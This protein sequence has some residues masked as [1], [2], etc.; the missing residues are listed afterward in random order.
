MRFEVRVS[1][2]FDFCYALADLISPDPHF[3]GWPAISQAPNWLERARALGWPLWLAVPDLI[4]REEPQESTDAFLDALGARPV[5]EIEP[6]LRRALFHSDDPA[7]PRPEKREWLHFIGLEKDSRGEFLKGWGGRVIDEVI[8]CLRGFQPEFDAAWSALLPQLSRSAAKARRAAAGGDLAKI[9]RTLD[10]AVEVDSGERVVRALRGGYSLPIGEVGTAYLMPSAFNSR[11]LWNAADAVR[12]A[13]LFFPFPVRDI[14]LPGPIRRTGPIPGT[15][16]DPWLV[17]RAA[18]DPTRAAILRLL[19]E[20]PRPASEL[21]AEL[22]LGKA[23][24]SHHIFQLR[25]ASLIDEKRRGRSIELAVRIAPLRL[26]GEAF[27]RELG[28]SK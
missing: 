8:A 19:A 22:G 6:A 25:Q 18:G 12:P 7:A 1:P 21:Q 11:G 24:I 14:R 5:T 3:T 26:L 4:E 2:Q 10:L 28:N 13:T 20:R 27:E 15:R 16:I 17:C 23:T 9:A